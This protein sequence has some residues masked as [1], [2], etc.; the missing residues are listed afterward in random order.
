MRTLRKLL[1]VFIAS[2][3]LMSQSM[4]MAATYDSL[5]AYGV[6]TI[7]GYSTLLSTS[8]TYPNQD[9]VFLVKK[10]DGRTISIPAKS[11]VSGVAKVD[12]YDYHTR[13]AGDYYVSSY[14]KGYQ[15]EGPVSTFRVYPDEVSVEKSSIVAQK[16]VV[17]ADGNDKAYLTVNIVDQY[18]NPFIGHVV[19]VISSRADDYVN[20]STYGSTT[21]INGSVTFTASSI[22]PGVSIFSAVDA[23]SG[24]V[25]T[26]RADVAFLNNS[27]YLDDAGG[28]LE[29]YIPVASAEDAGPLNK[30][31]VS[32]IPEIVQPN[33]NVS[34]SVT[35]QDVN[36]LTVENF[37]GTIHFSAE[38]PNSINVT[39]PEDYTFKAEDLGTHQFS[40][41][42]KF[43]ETGTY[44]I[45][46]TNIN[47]QNIK[48][49]ENVAVS[50]GSG[51]EPPSG[52]G[53]SLTISTPVAGTYSQLMGNIH[54]RQ[55]NSLTVSMQFMLFGWTKVMKS[56]I[57]RI[58]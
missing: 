55:Y 18:G 41:G 33:T 27:S 24:V 35:A 51:V 53:E 38:G 48:G 15:A 13:R 43:T 25:L 40:L 42:L 7:A 22:D 37:T 47:D 29:Y 32:G 31:D 11:D 46:A 39:L 26:S 5:Q 52:S 28:I 45:V 17:K 44:K 57:H 49:E 6:D 2:F 21:D 19:K 54:L 10:P 9:V 56:R 30:F 50:T 14:L 34:F 3:L 23:T 36:G 58:R 16:S 12:L 4:V 1:L 20:I 8:K